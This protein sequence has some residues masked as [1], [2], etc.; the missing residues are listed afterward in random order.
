MKQKKYH[1][2]KGPYFSKKGK[3]KDYNYLHNQF[4]YII[5][6]VFFMLVIV[7]LVECGI[8]DWAQE[9]FIEKCINIYL[10][11]RAIEHNNSQIL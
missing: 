5:F 4:K 2:R 11:A 6:A 8:V 1:S 10:F 7:G 3:S 9:N